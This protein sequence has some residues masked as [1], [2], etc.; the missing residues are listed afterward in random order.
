MGVYRKEMKLFSNQ[1]MRYVQFNLSD[2]SSQ[3]S[4]NILTSYENSLLG[5]SALEDGASIMAKAKNFEKSITEENH[6]DEFLKE[7]K[8]VVN[9]IKSEYGYKGQDCLLKSK[10]KFT[11]SLL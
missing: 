1:I 4:T 5:S 7:F 2:E 9:K 8:S 3:R 6:V 11:S 10:W